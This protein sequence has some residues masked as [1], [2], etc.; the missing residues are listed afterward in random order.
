M[1]GGWA[2]LFLGL[3]STCEGIIYEGM[4][5]FYW[6]EDENEEYL[7]QPMILISLFP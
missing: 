5:E 4:P 7:L 2:R 3:L 6:G 1:H